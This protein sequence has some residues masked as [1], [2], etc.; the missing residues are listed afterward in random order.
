MTEKLQKL[1]LVFASSARENPLPFLVYFGNQPGKSPPLGGGA[2]VRKP[3]P[4]GGRCHGL[5]VTDEG[6]CTSPI[7]HPK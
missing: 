6:K 2:S 5:A 1:F 4:S 7:W 3:S